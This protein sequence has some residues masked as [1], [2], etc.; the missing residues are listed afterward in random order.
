[1]ISVFVLLDRF[2]VYCH[3]C[4]GCIFFSMLLLSGHFFWLLS[5]IFRAYLA[6]QC[7][8]I[9]DYVTGLFCSSFFLRLFPLSLSLS[10]S[11]PIRSH[12]FPRLPPQSLKFGA[13]VWVCHYYLPVRS[14]DTY[15]PNIIWLFHMWLFYEYIS[16]IPCHFMHIVQVLFTWLIFS[17][18]PPLVLYCLA[19]NKNIARAPFTFWQC[20]Y[21][22]SF[23]LVGFGSIKI[24]L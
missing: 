3:S 24:C 6:S 5:F 11:H 9:N 21:F 22:G 4:L 19:K 18:W 12:L 23:S 13:H 10:L 14:G 17:F 2:V 20:V 15:Q 7:C 8:L 1:M 16:C